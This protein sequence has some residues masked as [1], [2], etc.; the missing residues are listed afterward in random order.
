MEYERGWVMRQIDMI[1][2]FLSIIFLKKDTQEFRAS[3][4]SQDTETDMLSRTLTELVHAGKIGEAENTLFDAFQ[5]TDAY[6]ALTLKFYTDL[7]SMTDTELENGGFS[8]E[9]I[10][11]GLED[12]TARFGVVLPMSDHFS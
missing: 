3:I 10:L 7:S 8:R 9:E 5:D 11:Q 12:I 2:R 1:V 4:I 6:R